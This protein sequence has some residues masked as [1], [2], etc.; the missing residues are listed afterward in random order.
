MQTEIRRP[1]LRGSQMVRALWFDRAL[2]GEEEAR[3]RLLAAWKSGAHAYRLADG[4]LIAWRQA[5]RLQC[6]TALGLPLC[7]QD[8]VLASAPLLA[9][10]RNGIAP[11]AAVMVVGAS[12]RVHALD[13][14]SRIDPSSWLDISAILVCVALTIPPNPQAG[15]ST[16]VP[17]AEPDLRALL[18]SVVP[19]P[20]ARR[21][22]FLRE[23]ARA[24]SGGRPLSSKAMGAVGILASLLL[25]PLALLPGASAAGAGRGAGTAL[26]PLADWLAA[27]TG[28]LATLTRI[29]RLLGWRQANYLRRMLRQFD[30]GNLDEALRHAIP[31]DSP[32]APS[33]QAFGLWNRRDK[34]DIGNGASAAGIGLDDR[35]IELLRATY[36]RSFDMLD[37]A[38]RIDEAVFV[39]AELMNRRQEAVDYLEKKG[40]IAQAARLAE[41]LELPAATA[42]RL[43]CMAGDTTRAVLLARLAGCFSEAVTELER[44]RDPGAAGL[45]LEWAR[46]LA[47]RGDLAE[48]ASAVWPLVQERERALAWLRE[49]EQSGGTPAVQGLIYLLALDPRSLGARSATLQMLLSS[50]APDAVQQRIRAA[51][52]LLRLD[53]HNSATRRLA[54]ALWRVLAAE[55][56]AGL[57]A[58]PGKNLTRLL[59]IASDPVLVDDLPRGGF[60]DVPAPPSLASRKDTL[61]LTFTE[62]GLYALEDVRALPDG[63]H[64]LALG[65]GGVVLAR[66]ASRVPLRFPVPAH[67]LVVSRNGRRALALARRE[68]AVRVSRIDLVSGKFEDWFSADLRFWAEEYDGASWSVIADERLMVLDATAQGQS[69]LWQVADLPGMVIDFVQQGDHQALLLRQGESV[70]QWRYVLPSRR[71]L[72]RDGVALSEST[73][74]VLCDCRQDA[75]VWLKA[76]LRSRDGGEACL[77]IVSQ[78]GEDKEIPWPYPETPQA[79]LHKDLLLLGFESGDGWHCRVMNFDCRI[80]ADIV[81]PKALGPRATAHAGHLLAWDRRGRVVDIDI[82]TAAIRTLTFG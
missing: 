45:R 44:R 11:G 38:G 36:Q 14:G 63:G 59:T 25:L 51:E 10:E 80:I 43:H 61:H 27:R 5:Q 26:S 21:S 18:G 33:R 34:L 79:S 7:E 1:L 46:D 64:L 15:F 30:E 29:A 73:F 32:H 9:H 68:K 39:L 53:S 52:C 20:S 41:T 78:Y 66:E 72:G 24:R 65:E 17:Q 37:R 13:A 56:G 28:K 71:L 48:A 2:L 62:Y 69:V 4:Y 70:E 42:V 74:S 67:H 57:H 55:R 19:P 47:A 23:A 77:S 12:L 54:S 75:P 22:T 81:L 35:S 58:L 16:A 82:E 40:R 6:E 50:S 76:G 31:L 3:R 8:G 49:A 60:A